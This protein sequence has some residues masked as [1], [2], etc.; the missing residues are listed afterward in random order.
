MNILP[1]NIKKVKFN[2]DISY[3]G[4]NDSQIEVIV[5]IT[6]IVNIAE[7]LYKLFFMLFLNILNLMK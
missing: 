2:N 6:C 1:P 3:S 4:I 7:L 5:T